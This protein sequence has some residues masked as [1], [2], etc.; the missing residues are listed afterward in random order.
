MEIYLQHHGVAIARIFLQEM[1][2]SICIRKHLETR[3]KALHYE[4]Q[5]G[6]YAS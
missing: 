3:K 5:A 6:N 2:M 1:L 4:S